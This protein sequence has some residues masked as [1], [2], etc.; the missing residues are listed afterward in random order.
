M[1]L[2][3]DCTPNKDHS[4][5]N[6]YAAH[7]G[8]DKIIVSTTAPEHAILT[9]LSLGV[10]LQTVRCRTMHFLSTNLISFPQ[11][12]GIVLVMAAPV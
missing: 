1:R 10:T 9:V 8:L 5:Y 2:T 12:R 6:V 11:L 4:L 3:A 7:H